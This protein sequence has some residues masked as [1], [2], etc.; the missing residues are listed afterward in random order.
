MTAISTL[1]RRDMLKVSS[2]LA[3]AVALPRSAKATPLKLLFV[4]G[5]GQGGFNLRG[6]KN[7]FA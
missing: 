4:H 1:C 2:A 6:S 7:D 3:L 5:R